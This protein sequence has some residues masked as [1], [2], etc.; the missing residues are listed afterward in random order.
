M[1]KDTQ[2]QKQNNF[3]LDLKTL[4]IN[5]AK[6]NKLTPKEQKKFLTLHALEESILVRD[7][8]ERERP[9]SSKKYKTS[10]RQILDYLWTPYKRLF[11]FTLVLSV[12]QALLFLLIPLFLQKGINDLLLYSDMNLIIVDFLTILAVLLVLAVIMYIRIYANNYIGTNIIKDLRDDLFRKVQDSTYGFLDNHPTGDLLSRSTSD[13]N[14]LKNLLSSQLAFFIRQS[15]TVVLSIAMM[16]Y[17]SPEVSIYACMTFPIIFVIMFYYRG[18]IRP[19]FV[20]S[21]ETNGELTSVVQEN[22]TGMRVVRAFAQEK[23]EIATFKKKNDLYFNQNQKLIFYQSSFEPI[24]RLLANLSVLLVILIG[25]N[26][27]MADY[28]SIMVGDLFA[29]I[30]LVNFAIDPLFFISRFLA[31]MPKVGA[32]CDRVT[33]ILNNPKTELGSDLPDLPAIRGV[34]EF[35]DVYVSYGGDDHH[36]LSG[37]NFKTKIGEKIAILGATGSGKSTLIRVIPRLYEIA[38]GQV[39]IDGNDIFKF[40]KHSLR[41]QIGI[42]PQETYLFGRSLFDNLT[43]G[44]PDASME[45]VIHATKLANIHDFIDSLPEKYETGVGERGVTLSGGQKQRIAIARALIIKPNILIL[46]DATSAVDVDTEYEIQRYFNEMFEH[47]TTFMI[48]QRLSTVRNADRII[49]L[50]HGKI[51][52]IGTHQELLKNS[53][54]IYSKLYLTLKVEE[55]S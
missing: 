27:A 8:K 22:I 25:T 50:K 54:G 26:M 55:R 28:N 1:V 29:L 51:A 45:E 18:K 40:N 17:I 6:F 11:T 42:V 47:S 2:K 31:D 41:K 19:T 48:T 5:E 10:F 30:M 37:I 7:R 12:I 52:E 53:E 35:K 14:L 3:S 44:R 15:L 4:G 34:I 9:D 20:A 24:V 46:D 33:G 23:Q 21:R 13:I 16:F 38:K 43:L 39:L 49:V 36:E 32:T